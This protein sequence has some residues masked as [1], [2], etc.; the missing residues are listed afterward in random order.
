MVIL[1][2]QYA[3]SRSSFNFSV[4]IKNQVVFATAVSNDS[5]TA[6]FQPCM[7]DHSSINTTPKAARA[8]DRLHFPPV[9]MHLLRHALEE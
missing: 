9:S 2:K 3:G 7:R 1:S 6:A 5:L 8:T 4:S